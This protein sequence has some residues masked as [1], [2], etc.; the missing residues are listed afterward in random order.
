MRPFILV[1]FEV[2]TII[3]FLDFYVFVFTHGGKNVRG[4]G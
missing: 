4:L 3:V 1:D 2:L